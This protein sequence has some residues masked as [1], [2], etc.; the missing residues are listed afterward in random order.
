MLARLAVIGGGAAGL[1]AAY[2][3]ERAGLEVSVL[4]A[5]PRFGGKIFSL[6]G[7]GFVVEAGPDSFPATPGMLELARELNL[8]HDLL[9]PCPD[10]NPSYLLYKG[11]T[12]ALPDVPP[13]QLPWSIGPLLSPAGRLR[14]A[15]ERFVGQAADPDE[16]LE[17]FIRRRFGDEAWSILARPLSHAVYGANPADLSVRSAFSGLWEREQKSAAAQDPND[18]KT[19]A[20]PVSFPGGMGAW[21][22]ALLLHLEGK[23]LAGTG[24][25]VVAISREGE[26]WQIFTSRGKLEAEAVIFATS[27]QRTARILRPIYPQA[28][29][30][31]N[32]VP[33]LS[34]A[35]VTLAFREEE[36]PTLPGHEVILDGNYR[37]ES[38]LWASKRWAGRAPEGFQLVRV[39]FAGE[40]ARLGDIDLTRLAQ[41]ELERYAGDRKMPKP[42]ASWPFRL[43][44][45]PVYQVGHGRRV[46][47]IEDAI[48]RM[49]GVFTAGLGLKGLSL[50]DSVREG[51]QAAQRALNYLAL[52]PSQHPSTQSSTP[53]IAEAGH[54]P[55]S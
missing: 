3:A 29:A 19:P 53:P 39:N 55:S 42:L 44:T 11:K 12:L 33:T 5:S 51:W 22:K 15:F 7:D 46:A 27:A 24:L 6:S 45:V 52:H 26:A 31:L 28:T 4:E 23:V 17:P 25:E 13:V 36:L 32:Q 21:V 18:P 8:T 37:A 54:S 38:F 14:L 47:A 34:V 30:L 16:G 48:D 1:A 50:A 20:R 49:P 9:S 35:T 43:G 40:V 10:P 2:Y 41:A